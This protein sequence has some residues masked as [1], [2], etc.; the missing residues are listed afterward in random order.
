MILGHARVKKHR[1][2]QVLFSQSILSDN[3]NCFKNNN[4]LNHNQSKKVV[5]LPEILIILVNL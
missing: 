4:H 3:P 1:K 2:L 5:M